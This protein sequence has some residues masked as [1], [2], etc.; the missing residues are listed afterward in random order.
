MISI[1]WQ[2]LDSQEKTSEQSGGLSDGDESDD[3][4]EEFSDPDFLA[5]SFSGIKF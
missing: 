4:S 5:W 3:D 1:L 2:L